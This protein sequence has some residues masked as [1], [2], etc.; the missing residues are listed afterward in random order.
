MMANS[1]ILRLLY[2]YFPTAV[3]TGQCLVFISEESKVEL[4][5]HRNTSFGLLKQTTP[6]I[7]VKIY[8]KTLNGDFVQGHYQDFQLDSLNELAQQ[9]ERYIQNAVGQNIR[10]NV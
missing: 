3:N 4:W 6:G 8:K 5:E 9:V 1:D 2:D 7:R 10:E